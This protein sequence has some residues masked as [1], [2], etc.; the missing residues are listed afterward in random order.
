M[1][2]HKKQEGSKIMVNTPITVARGDGIGPEIMEQVLNIL[3]AANARIDIE[4]ITI[5]ETAYKAGSSTGIDDSAWASLKKTGVLLK[6]PLAT[7]Q[8]GGYKSVNVT[9]RKML[10]MYANV[11]PCVSYAPFVASKSPKMDMVIVRENVED[12]YGGMEYRSSQG[13]MTALKTITQEGSERIARYAFEYARANGR[14]KV[15]C[16]TKDN[17]L[18][19]TD[20]LFHNVFD[21]VGAEY[22]DIAKEHYIVDIGSARIS[23]RPEDFDVVLT[24]NLYGDI[25]SDIAAEGIGSVGLGGSANIGE[26]FAMFEAIHGT[27]PSLAGKD[28]GSPSGLLLAS[29]MMLIHIGQ[30]D[31]AEK[32]HNAWL[33]TIEDGI[34]TQDAYRAGVSSQKAGTKAFGQAVIDRLGQKP[35]KFAVVSYPAT[36]KKVGYGALKARAPEAKERV[37]I[38]VFID[39]KGAK[40]E[41]LA[42]IAGKFSKDLYLKDISNLGTSV[43]PAGGGDAGANSDSW[44]LR[45]VSNKGT[46][47]QDKIVRLL[48]KFNAASLDV[49]ATE[50]L[51]T[52]GGKAGYTAAQG[53]KNAPKLG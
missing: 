47:T 42:N 21:E 46:V 24:E 30:P 29:V 19:L 35:Q 7:P 16:M 34:H 31:V 5:G 48:G 13:T 44:R 15:T 52:F 22:P 28:M 11:R 39:A 18:K 26:N 49:T 27:A 14:K 3:K 43:W 45:F 53:E 4:E 32:I 10:G 20:G 41:T 36:G 9:L 17:I 23:S 1:H 33:R 25:I 6:A 38:D 8:G 12:L 37:G 40:A 2:K 51:Y 50:T